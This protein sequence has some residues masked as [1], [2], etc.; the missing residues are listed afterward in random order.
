MMRRKPMNRAYWFPLVCLI[1]FLPACLTVE[2]ISTRILFDQ[3]NDII[4]I[5]ILYDNIAS[6][7]KLDK[8]IEADFEYLI[9]QAEDEGYLLERLEQGFYIKKRRLFIDNGKIMAEEELITRDAESL[10]KEFGLVLDSTHWILPLDKG[11]DDFEVIAHNGELL[12]PGDESCLSWP[13]TINEIYWKSRLRTVPATFEQ[14][15]KQMV[16]RLQQYLKDAKTAR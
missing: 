5:Y 13:R 9:G 11:Q 16:Q 7:E 8:D 3:S 1:L 6:A 4:R 15:R 2:I 12:G 14:N 10:K